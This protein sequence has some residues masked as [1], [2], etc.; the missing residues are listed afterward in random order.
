MSLM[1]FENLLKKEKDVAVEYFAIHYW[2][3]YLYL[4]CYSVLWIQMEK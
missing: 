3:D 4:Q 2:M 1:D